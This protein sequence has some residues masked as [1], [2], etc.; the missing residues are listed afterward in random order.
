MDA[1]ARAY[2]WERHSSHAGA[3]RGFSLV[4]VI[5][6]IMIISLFAG[7][8]IPRMAGISRSTGKLTVMQAADL[9]SAF[10]YRDSI[11]SGKSALRYDGDARA[12]SL[13]ADRSERRSSAGPTWEPDGLAPDLYL[14]DDFELTA[15]VDGSLLPDG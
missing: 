2:Y 13:M 15:F 10:A 6:V 9:L 7:L 8:V 12:V 14:P 11:S 3:S 5:L 1:D 4:E